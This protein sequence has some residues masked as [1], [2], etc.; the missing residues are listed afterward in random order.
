MS[1]PP[2]SLVPR[3]EVRGGL[4]GSS[5][6]SLFLILFFVAKGQADDSC[7]GQGFSGFYRNTA[8]YGSWLSYV[9]G[10][11]NGAATC[12]VGGRSTLK[13]CSL[14]NSSCSGTANGNCD[15]RGTW[16]LRSINGSSFFSTSDQRIGNKGYPLGILSAGTAVKIAVSSPPPKKPRQEKRPSNT[17]PEIHPGPSNRC[18]T[19]QR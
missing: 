8:A 9:C 4:G 18:V 10:E 14:S 5:L 11:S 6:V 13:V 17:Q 1:A 7:A 3:C 16:P 19:L 12:A 2:G 15:V